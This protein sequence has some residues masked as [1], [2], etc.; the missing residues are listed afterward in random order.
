[1]GER[2]WGAN[3]RGRENPYGEGGSIR[4]FL[5]GGLINLSSREGGIPAIIQ[6]RKAERTS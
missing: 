2:L 3:E 6:E 1:M 5:I 4:L